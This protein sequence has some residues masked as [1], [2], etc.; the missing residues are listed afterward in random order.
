MMKTKTLWIL[1]LLSGLLTN[2]SAQ[3]MK[4][5]FIGIQ[6]MITKEKFYDKGEFDLNI[7]P[8]VVQVSL[9]ELVEIRAISI[10]NMHFGTSSEVSHV[11]A[12]LGLPLYPFR[13]RESAMKGIY[14]APVFAMVHNRVT[15]SK[16]YTFAIEPGY[17]W[18]FQKG[19]SMNAGLQLGGTYFDG[20]F[21]GNALKDHFG[22]KISLGYSF[23]RDKK[24]KQDT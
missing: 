13:K 16:E 6:P 1:I 14:A 2:I 7:V 12:E 11:G 18:I 19:F 9:S 4:R 22:F 20:T 17:S 3:N 10:V 24:N 23:F 21:D 15:S 5:T 8:L